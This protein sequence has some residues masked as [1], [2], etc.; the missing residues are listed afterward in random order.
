MAPKKATCPDCGRSFAPGYLNAHRRKAHGIRGGNTGI[1]RQTR[2][3][4]A[5]GEV[6]SRPR[7]P[8]GEVTLANQ[9]GDFVLTN[10]ALALRFRLT[11]YVVLVD[12]SGQLWIAG[13]IG[14]S[15]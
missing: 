8:A 9:P 3:E 15:K 6:R 7:R 12:E 1:V 10:Q 2:A 14:E 11:Q 4:K 13:P 5:A